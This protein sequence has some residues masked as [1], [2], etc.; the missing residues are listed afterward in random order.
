MSVALA[1][2]REVFTSNDQAVL[3][4]WD[5]VEAEFWGE[6]NEQFRAHEARLSDLERA[7]L[8]DRCQDH[9]AWGVFRNFAIEAKREALDER[10]RMIAHATAAM[11]NVNLTF[12]ELARAPGFE[13][14]HL[15]FSPVTIPGRSPKGKAAG[16]RPGRIGMRSAGVRQ[17]LGP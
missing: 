6:T 14:E 7:A 12:G 10:R 8:E 3:A 17:R 5:E 13:V 4:K 16:R 15:H 1:K 2:L 9:E 11:A